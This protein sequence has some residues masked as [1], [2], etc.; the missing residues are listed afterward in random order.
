MQL[1]IPMKLNLNNVIF[2][3]DSLKIGDCV[4]LKNLHYHSYLCGE[5]IIVDGLYMQDNMNYF[6]DCI[7]RVQLQR[8]YCASLELDS[9]AEIV[10]ND[11]GKETPDVVKYLTAL[12]VSFYNVAMKVFLFIVI[13]REDETMKTY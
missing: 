9:Y 7:F 3:L 10:A 11:G 4:T 6:D 13:H 2:L 12:E 5:G 8:Q 1:L